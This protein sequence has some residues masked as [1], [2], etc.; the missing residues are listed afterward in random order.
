MMEADGVNCT[1]R[2]ALLVP[3]AAAWISVQI[4]DKKRVWGLSEASRGS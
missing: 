3:G 1:P 4:K 2:N